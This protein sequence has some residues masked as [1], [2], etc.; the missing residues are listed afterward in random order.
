MAAVDSITVSAA[1]T[2]A[3]FISERIR[4]SCSLAA[5]DGSATD[6]MRS[7]T[8]IS[9]ASPRPWWNSALTWS[10]SSGSGT[11][12]PTAATSSSRSAVTSGAY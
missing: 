5:T 10:N 12:A 6:W 7:R 2:S 4:T 8:R 11:S 9:A 1:L 3:R